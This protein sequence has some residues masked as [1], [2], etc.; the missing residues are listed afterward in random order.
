MK[1]FTFLKSI[2]AIMGLLIVI[3]VGCSKVELHDETANEPQYQ[4]MTAEDISVMNK[5]VAFRDKLA[6][7]RENPDFKSGEVMSAEDARWNIE[8]LFNVTY[9]FPDE[10]YVRTKADSVTMYL[11]VSSNG[12]SSVNDVIALYEDC[13]AL[14]SSFY[15]NSS[16]QNK[17]FVLLTL[18]SGEIVN[19]QMQ[20][21]LRAVTGEKDNQ[22]QPFSAND[23]L[24]YGYLNGYCNFN[25]FSETDAAQKIQE[26]IIANKPLISV[27]PPYRLIYVLDPETITRIGNEYTNEQNEYLIFYIAREDGNFTPEDKC[28]IPDE[29][30]FHF[31]GQQEVIYSRLPIELEKPSNWTFMNCVITG[32]Q[33]SILNENPYIHHNNILTY[34]YRYVVLIH[35][36]PLPVEL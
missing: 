26:A 21:F 30:N 15:H 1:K 4:T 36:I 18:N 32:K 14:V 6:Y 23:S 10:R 25:N 28:L 11:P 9:G 33:E 29:M 12:M 2:T 34:A 24:Y 13:I 31:F 16:F 35:E 19:G 5:I 8:T 17:G 27:P 20:V 22:W 3:G 7:H